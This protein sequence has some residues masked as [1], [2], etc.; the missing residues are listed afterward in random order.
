MSLTHQQQAMIETEVDIWMDA[1][2]MFTAFEISRAVK[3]KGIGLR[4]REMKDAVH[5][6]IAAKRSR[7][8]SRTLTDVGAPEQAWLYHPLTKNPHQF[9]PL[10]RNDGPSRAPSPNPVPPAPAKSLSTGNPFRPRNLVPLAD[11]ESPRSTASDGAYGCDNNGHLKIPAKEMQKIGVAAD[12]TVHVLGDPV[13][14]SVLI[15][16]PGDV[17]PDGIEEE[18]TNEQGDLI[19]THETLEFVD[20]DWLPCYKVEVEGKTL[21][22]TELN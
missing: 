6:A 15:G 8:Y 12:E 10:Q 14:S 16:R 4:H 2:R 21:K 22:V 9:T 11:N 13:H 17:E 7:T 3:A 1:E 5:R 19:V 20:L 18:R